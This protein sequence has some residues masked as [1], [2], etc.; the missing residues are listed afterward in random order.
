MKRVISLVL[1]L[2]MLLSV[3]TALAQPATMMDR[4]A[5]L[6][7]AVGLNGGTKT[8]IQRAD[9]LERQLGI[10]PAVGATLEAR[11]AALEAA[12]GLGAPGSLPFDESLYV[13]ATSLADLDYF[14]KDDWV[15]MLEDYFLYEEDNYGNIYDA[16]LVSCT[17]EGAIEYRLGGDY[18]LFIGYVYVPDYALKNGY[19]HYWDTAELSIYGDDQLL[20]T[21]S[22]FN[23]KTEPVPF[24]LNVEGVKFLK[25]VFDH[26]ILYHQG[27]GSPLAAIGKPALVK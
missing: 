5:Q 27:S 24:A 11:V 20:F 25:V 12:L 7:A 6:E 8:L 9:E 14:T 3:G 4:V 26:T 13:N 17:E 1:A 21:I 19:H 2:V 22:G 16:M 18:R 15:Y 10:V 23:E